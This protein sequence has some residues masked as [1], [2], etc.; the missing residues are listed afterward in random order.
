VIHDTG[1]RVV[2]SAI[3]SLS[4]NT[5]SVIAARSDSWDDACVYDHVNSPVS[6]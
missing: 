1:G 2:F 4:F 6:S 3:T 5:T